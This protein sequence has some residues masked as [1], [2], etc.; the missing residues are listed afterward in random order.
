MSACCSVCNRYPCPGCLGAAYDAVDRL[1]ERVATLEAA[2]RSAALVLDTA[3]ANVA[4]QTRAEPVDP[5]SY[6]ILTHERDA[7]LALLP[8]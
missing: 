1:K 7:C 2:L 6:A 3:A 8:A 5:I 4:D